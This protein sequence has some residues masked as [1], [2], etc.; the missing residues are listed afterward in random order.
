MAS[1]GARGDL[2]SQRRDTPGLARTA[3]T[4]GKQTLVERE[5]RGQPANAPAPREVHLAQAAPLAS[6]PP[7]PPAAVTTDD[8]AWAYLRANHAQCVAAIAQRLGTIA[9]PHHAR[10][11]WKPR[12]LFLGFADALNAALAGVPLFDRL[13]DLLD[14]IDPWPIIDAHR[15]L[16]DGSP[17]VIVDGREPRG[18]LT[19]NPLVGVALAIEVAHAVREALAR[20]APRFVERAVHDASEL[21]ASHPMDRV[22]AYLLCDARVVAM[23]GRSG[24]VRAKTQVRILQR[25]GWLGD[26]DAS[27]WNWLEV[28]DPAPTVEDVAATL[29]GG[30]QHTQRA[31]QIEAA[32]PYF[33]VEPSW[34]RTF[35]AAKA[36]APEGL[37][38][39]RDRDILALAD[40]RIAGDLA[41][42]QGARRDHESTG[43]TPDLA[44][45][46]KL[47]DKSQRQLDDAKGILL[48]TRLREHLLPAIH[49]V[50][51]Q[52]T[53]L[54]SFPSERLRALTPVIEDQQ[55]IL[56]EAVG[57][58]KLLCGSRGA[59][60]AADGPLATVLR[61]YATAIGTSH[62]VETARAQLATA[63]RARDGLAL[64]LLDRSFTAS[65]ESVRELRAS[66]TPRM[67]YQ[68][69]EAEAT[70][71]GYEQQLLELR[72][73]QAEGKTV[74]D[75]DIALLAA[76]T[77][78]LAF[79]AQAKALYLQLQQLLVEA[80]D[81]Q[82]GC[83]EA[84][85]SA[86]S[87][88][89][90]GLGDK[91][92]VLLEDLDTN[93]IKAL[94]RAKSERLRS[95]SASRTKS[96]QAWAT[97]EAVRYVEGRLRIFVQQHALP[98][99]IRNAAAAIDA[100]HSRTRWCRAVLQI[101]LL[102][103]VSVVGGMVG[104]VVTVAMRSALLA[105]A[106]IASAGAVRAISVASSVA[107]VATDAAINALGQKVIVGGDA[108]ASF[109]DN[110]VSSAALRVALAPLHNAASAW[111]AEE[112]AL[113][114]A[115]ETTR[116]ARAGRVLR[117]AS[118]LTAEMLTGAAVNYLVQRTL[119]SGHV[120]AKTAIDWAQEGASM[121]IGA[122]IGHRLKGLE[123]RLVRLAAHGAQLLARTRRI[124]A[125]AARLEAAG[126]RPALALEILAQ[127]HELLVEEARL[128]REYTA[129]SHRDAPIDPRALEALRA[130]NRAETAGVRDQAFAAMTLRLTGLEPEDASA[131]LWRG[132]DVAAALS[133]ARRAGL[134]V[135][136]RAFDEKT[137][138]WKVSYNERELT[139]VETQPHA[140][141]GAPAASASTKTLR[142]QNHG[143]P[144]AD[145]TIDPLLPHAYLERRQLCP[146]RKLGAES[147]WKKVAKRLAKG[148]CVA[149][150]TMLRSE[151]DGHR[152]LARLAAG[153]STALES[154]GIS[155]VPENLDSMTREWA[156]VET[157]DGYAIY[158]GKYGSVSVRADVRLLG[159]THPGPGIDPATGASI[160]DLPFGEEGASYDAIIADLNAASA[161]AIIPSDH[162]IHA[163][164]D[165][166]AH[167]IHTRYV[168][169]G[170][171]QIANPASAGQRNQ[172][173]IHLRDTKVLRWDPSRHEYFYEVQVSVKDAAGEILWS[174]QMYSLWRS[175]ARRG[176]V[177]VTRP[178]ELDR[179]LPPG[180][181][182]P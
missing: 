44:Q 83:A 132:A 7:A 104:N 18:P 170:N 128:L 101:A 106:A 166:G 9:P 163:V 155:G 150:G 39:P 100:Q 138:T 165:G 82:S 182:E 107:G 73:R 131:T 176:R 54:W 67:G 1:H 99:T 136:L 169:I 13:P 77:K 117:Q 158:V 123:D 134:E 142:G 108:S 140:E 66:E 21:V 6:A 97:N 19:W 162:D 118:V 93:V 175:F 28:G 25:W 171:K 16:S 59:A 109:I 3:P 48:E 11:A 157:R 125:T 135:H 55:A 17:G 119:H 133:Q 38:R 53:H 174:G 154:I 63:H 69:A 36:H 120:D 121:V 85:A 79:E 105:D 32:P 127:H 60:N 33:R 172:V 20:M 8:V 146:F 145:P 122:F 72:A 144:Y 37:D 46:T 22:A 56:F 29:A 168:H 139:I 15:A 116:A 129:A 65:R 27:L 43:K 160:R 111:Q 64:D 180:W 78:E 94:P 75:D 110:L 40:S 95:R 130:G 177:F 68:G 91:L 153:D 81:A 62:L 124:R 23:V 41:I 98:T 92:A 88:D 4:P 126:G 84:L 57:E 2:E 52:R 12:G 45:L 26:R 51:T 164:S 5:A 148:E 50:Q 24:A 137:R 89:F 178:P 90:R 47:L 159:H 86:F 71:T 151:A 173:S 147:S 181:Q 14:P 141:H 102:I 179:P 42:A 112:K 34:A 30:I 35:P 161:A 87:S 167:T 31:N 113:A 80:S 143:G 70:A 76:Q 149:I 156:V 10:L 115:T 49:W 58:L 152:V 103:G 61:H 74:D 96:D 114:A